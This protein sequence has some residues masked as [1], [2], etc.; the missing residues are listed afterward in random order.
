MNITAQV[1]ETLEFM[2][3][4]ISMTL[5]E[6]GKVSPMY[7][8]IV[9]G[10]F[11]PVIAQENMSFQEYEGIVY[12]AAA[13]VQANALVLISEQ[14]MVARH[15]DDPEAQL[16]IDGVIRPGDQDDKETYLT[17]VYTDN[18]GLSETLA[19]K[20]EADPSGTRFTRE[21]TWV[22]ECVSSLI[23]PWM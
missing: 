14:W 17:L 11:I 20:V 12:Q 19:A 5:T 10:Q 16:L 4:S 2:F 7:L 1:K 3:T 8:M 6:H 13:S 18:K 21:P 15:K 9:E 23:A 22:E